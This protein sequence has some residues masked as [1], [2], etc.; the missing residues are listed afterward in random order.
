M[1]GISRLDAK[2][3]MDSG[4]YCESC[5][6]GSEKLDKLIKSSQNKANSATDYIEWIPFGK[7]DDVKFVASGQYGSVSSAIW[8]DGPR[9]SFNNETNSWERT[10]PTVVA[11]K[12]IN[13]SKHL[14]ASFFQELKGFYNNSI[15]SN[16]IVHCYGISR[17]P[18][19]KNYIVVMENANQGSLYNYL[20]NNFANITWNR[21]LNIISDIVQGL[22]NIHEAKLV[23]RNL[24]CGNILVH[25]GNRIRAAIGDE[26]LEEA[27]K[28][29]LELCNDRMVVTT[30]STAHL[31]S[32]EIKIIQVSPT[33]LN[34]EIYNIKPK[35]HKKI[36]FGLKK[37][38]QSLA[39][40][41]EKFH[42]HADST[43]FDD[44][45]NPISIVTLPETFNST[46]LN[47]ELTDFTKKLKKN[48][49]LKK[50]EKDP[51]I[52]DQRS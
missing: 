47:L 18:K 36:K 41:N 43:G 17:D 51:H 40:K 42:I 26:Q 34:L 50:P 45:S 13:D 38:E 32:R 20:V 15:E 31:T 37:P 3:R 25:S 21:K 33:K 4:A 16:R 27:E 23:H 22:K 30:P 12:T 7:L 39:I 28:I 52:P 14:S 2:H 24:H 10:G 1:S 44:I 6:S 19:T 46:S 5:I 11:L 35:S 29:R 9:L 8:M 49:D 48:K